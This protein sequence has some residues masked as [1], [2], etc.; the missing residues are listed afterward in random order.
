MADLLYDPE[1]FFKK[2]KSDFYSNSE[3][4]PRLDQYEALTAQ[5]SD[6]RIEMFQ[7]QIGD[8]S[9]LSK[10][11]V[12]KLSKLIRDLEEERANSIDIKRL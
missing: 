9:D 8:K 12:D 10:Y 11:M 6:R 5:I 4:L 2:Q 7:Y 1:G 3:L